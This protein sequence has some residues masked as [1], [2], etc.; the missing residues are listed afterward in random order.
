MIKFNPKS[1]QDFKEEACEKIKKG[2]CPMCDKKV[3]RANLRDL[4]SKKEFD[5]SGFCQK[6]QD[7]VFGK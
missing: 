1:L 3:E 5:I 4:L 6:C 2:I 7:K